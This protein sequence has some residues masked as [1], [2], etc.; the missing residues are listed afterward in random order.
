M[1][2]PASARGRSLGLDF[3]LPPGG[4]RLLLA[5]AVLASHLSSLDIGRLAVM[6]FFY[7][8]GYWTA[9][10]WRQKFAGSALLRFYAA[11]YLRV[12]PLFF[13][14]TVAAGLARNLPLHVE[15]W[16]LFGVGST[17]RDPTGVSWSL[18]V[19]VQFYLLLPVVVAALDRM[20]LAAA[21]LTALAIGAPGMCWASASLRYPDGGQIPPGLRPRLT[22]L[23]EGLGS[24][25][26]CGRRLLAG[27]RG[28]DVADR[29][30]ALPAQDR[31]PAVRLRYLRLLLDAAPPA[32]RRALADV[33]VVA[34]GPSPRQSKLPTLSGAC[35]PD[36]RREGAFRRRRSDQSGCSRGRLRGFALY[37]TWLST[38]LSIA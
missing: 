15:N 6:L 20:S 35:A 26:R 10:I 4:F 23:S 32:V 1:T 18:D 14:V 12:W 5:A 9:L 27:V 16:I 33:A 22:H 11:R 29:G 8:S 25:P 24:R 36:R 2:Q 38:D 17:H 13:L 34:T 30:H 7:L 31:R 19:E 21:I 28:R 3:V 37:S